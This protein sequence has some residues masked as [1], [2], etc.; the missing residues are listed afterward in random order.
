[1]K[2][3]LIY[4]FAT[5]ITMVLGLLSRKFMFIFPDNIA[6]FIGDMLWATMIYFG[7][8][9]LF[10]KFTYFKS[11]LIAIIFSY[12][13]EFSQLYKANWIMNLRATTL[14]ALILGHGF[15]WQDLIFYTGGILLALFIDKVII[16]RLK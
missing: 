16:K 3:K 4:F 13:I 1:M 14:G 2:I 12:G 10:S 5:I 8:K 15:L 6:P 9:F 11:F 7:F